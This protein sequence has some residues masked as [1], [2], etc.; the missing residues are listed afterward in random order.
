MY[1]QS[2]RRHRKTTT[3]LFA[4][5]QKRDES[6]KEFLHRFNTETLEV[7]SVDE[8][9]AIAS[10]MDGLKISRFLFSLSKKP[11]TT[12]AK[13]LTKAERYIA[14]DDLY[15]AKRDK[16]G[17]RRDRKRKELEKS[18]LE[19]NGSSKRGDTC[20][21]LKE[22]IEALI[23]RGYLLEHLADRGQHHSIEKSSE[24]REER[25]P[26]HLNKPTGGQINVIHGGLTSSRN[27]MS[28]HRAHLRKAKR[29][30]PK[31]VFNI[32]PGP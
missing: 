18:R 1:F 20:Y 2:S 10:L 6:L 22:E 32:A 25:R 11:P 9:V 26:E 14:A 19:H 7:D 24:H 16:E 21:K 31:D 29:G 3:H 12:I 17:D 5:R 15:N 13:L 8:K 23:K 28:A 27:S 30:P 4:L